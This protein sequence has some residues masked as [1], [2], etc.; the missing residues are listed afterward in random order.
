MARDCPDCG[1]PLAINPVR[2][3]ACG[4][5]PGG[6]QA[7]IDIDA[8]RCSWL[9]GTERCHYAGTMS[10]N[11]TGGGPWYCPGHYACDDGAH[12]QR[13]VDE[14]RRAMYGKNLTGD[15]VKAAAKRTFLARP[16]P[17]VPPIPKGVRHPPGHG[18]AFAKLAAVLARHSPRAEE[19]SE[20]MAI[21]R[22]NDVK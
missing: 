9:A 1:E 21:Q 15:S 17:P 13:I 4:Y 22:E 2:C 7:P 11:T 18:G 3:T 6:K 20:R 5:R 12:G 16:I 19:L 8:M 10:P 14:S